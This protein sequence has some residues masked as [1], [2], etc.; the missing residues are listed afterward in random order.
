M[1]STRHIVVIGANGGIGHQCVEVGLAAGYQVTALVRNPAKL[2]LSHPNLSVLQADVTQPAT[3]LKHLMNKD[4]I[5]SAIGSGGIGHDPLTT[6]YSQGAATVL[7]QMKKANAQRVF[8]ISSCAI[9]ISPVNSLFVRFV[10]K[11]VI[12]NLLKNMFDD[13]RRMEAIVKPSEA[14]WT[15]IRPPL[16]TN[17][18]LTGHYRYAMNEFLPNCT[19]ISRADLAHFMIQHIANPATFRTTIEVAY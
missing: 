1:S 17:G 12:G 9:E 6:L 7:A 18:A 2:S 19:K 10:E 4:A 11:Y 16:L 15:L 13:I 3:L 14:D 5:I 8:F